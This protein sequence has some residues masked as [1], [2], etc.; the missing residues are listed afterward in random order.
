MIG[1]LGE[2]FGRMSISLPLFLSINLLITVLSQRDTICTT[3]YYI[4]IYPNAIYLIFGHWWKIMIVEL[5]I[6]IFSKFSIKTLHL[7]I[8]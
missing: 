4:Y 6:D 7:Q 5:Y 2:K 1:F 8:R 3:Q